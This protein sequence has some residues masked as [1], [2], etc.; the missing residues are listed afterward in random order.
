MSLE[1]G[2]LVL[3]LRL[4]FEKNF[5][6]ILVGGQGCG[7]RAH[8]CEAATSG[9]LPLSSWFYPGLLALT[10]HY[11]LPGD[12][13]LGHVSSFVFLPSAAF[14]WDV[15]VGGLCM[16]PYFEM[17]SVLFPGN[18]GLHFFRISRSFLSNV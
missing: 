13:S 15:A 14:P 7:S 17:L 1:L 4:F 6:V 2:A 8:P 9:Q 3:S 5:A 10:Y 11:L 12:W 16:S 18:I